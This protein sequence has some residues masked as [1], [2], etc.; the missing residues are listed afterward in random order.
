[1]DINQI[2]FQHMFSI[3][4]FPPSFLAGSSVWRSTR[5][6]HST[7]ST[8]GRLSWRASRRPW[9]AGSWRSGSQQR[10][11]TNWLF[12]WLTSRWKASSNC[13]S[14]VQIWYLMHSKWVNIFEIK[15]NNF[16]PK[17]LNSVSKT[18]LPNRWS[19]RVTM[20]KKRV[21]QTIKGDSLFGIDFFQLAMMCWENF[22]QT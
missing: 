22:W 15:N 5:M 9:T 18:K 8:A 20:H 1:V 10:T 3:L 14:I 12:N 19:Q 2:L 11:H 13:E 21:F 6:I 17:D 16:P 4:T 7:W